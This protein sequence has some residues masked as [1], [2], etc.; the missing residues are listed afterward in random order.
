M[1]E[2]NQSIGQRKK[3]HAIAT[4]LLFTIYQFSKLFV[5]INFRCVFFFFLSFI[6]SLVENRQ[7]NRIKLISTDKN[8][9][10]HE[11]VSIFFS[12]VFSFFL[13]HSD[14]GCV[15]IIGAIVSDWIL[16]LGSQPKI[17]KVNMNARSNDVQWQ[18]ANNN[19]N[20]HLTTR[21]QK[22]SHFSLLFLFNAIWFIRYSLFPFWV[23][24]WVCL[25]V[26]VGGSLFLC[27]NLAY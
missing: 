26:S 16:D 1:N 5:A 17:I 9:W 11:L 12:L 15:L 27:A 2:S 21:K 13:M 22:F 23:R 6:H 20:Y 25:F 14:V 24:E 10:C 7:I 4:L 8:R 19:N 18:I 3:K